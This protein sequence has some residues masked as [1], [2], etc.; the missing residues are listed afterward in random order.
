VKKASGFT[1]IELMLTIAIFAIVVAAAAP[2]MA[3]FVN[4]YRSEAKGRALFD[5]LFLMRAKAYSE[6]RNYSLCPSSDGNNCSGDWA[7]GV[8]LF[9][10]EDGDG[11]RDD[12]ETIERTLPRLEENAS[13]SWR[14]FNNRGYLI[15][16][17]SGTTPSQSG[18]FAYCPG[19]GEAKYGWFII[20]N[21]IG[22]PY[23]GKDSDGDGIVE[24]GSGDNL[25]CGADG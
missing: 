22:R 7:A 11:E 12:G 17:P 15:F 2:S 13:L 14:A 5:L 25:D 24:N 6:G 9:A 3:D 1:L 18:N 4:R 23:F 10:D 19:S 20:L 8:L 21:K 16:R